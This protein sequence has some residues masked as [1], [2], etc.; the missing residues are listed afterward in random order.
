MSSVSSLSFRDLGQP[1][2]LRLSEGANNHCER[3]SITNNQIGPS[4]ATPF[5]GHLSEPEADISPSRGHAP[6]DQ[7]Q[8]RRALARRDLGTYASGQW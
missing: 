2:H 5:G 6:S 4:Y 3:A 1:V 7:T 8:H